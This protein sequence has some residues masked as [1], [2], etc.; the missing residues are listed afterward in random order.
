MSYVINNTRGQIVAIVPDGTINTAATPVT[1]VGRGVTSYGEYENE[2]YVYLLE[3]FANSSAPPNPVLG[4]LW[5]NSSTDIISN[6]SSA[7]TWVA[8]ATQSY[9]NTQIVNSKVNPTFTGNVTV[10]GNVV[11]SGSISAVGDITVGNI[12][13]TGTL[14]ANS[15]ATGSSLFQLAQLSQSEINALSPVNGALVYNTTVDYVQCY[16]AGAWINMTVARY[17]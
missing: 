6:Y 2:N 10:N 13:A 8:L 4:Q 7:N 14:T 16:Q 12:I 5:Y 15:I 1:L 11:V 9:V 3:N 17:S